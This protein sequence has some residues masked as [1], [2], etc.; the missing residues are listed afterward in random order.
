MA[1]ICWQGCIATHCFIVTTRAATTNVQKLMKY[2]HII[3]WG[4]PLL[5]ASI[6]FLVQISSNFK[7]L[8]YGP[9]GIW[10]F[11]ALDWQ[12]VFLMNI[13]VLVLFLYNVILYAIIL[14][15]CKYSGKSKASKGIDRIIVKTGL[16][17]LTFCF[18]WSGPSA[19][20]LQNLMYPGKP[21]FSLY[22]LH[23]LTVASGGFF[24]ALIYL[25]FLWKDQ[26][27]KFKDISLN[28]IMK[29]KKDVVTESS[30]DSALSSMNV[31]NFSAMQ[32]TPSTGV[33]STFSK[34][35]Y[36]YRP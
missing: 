27:S 8:A 16:Y 32:S 30:C 11:S 36:T 22:F 13:P 24:N 28:K 15:L 26:K 4:F 23:A 18:V 29:K 31:S 6:P 7:V 12:R 35:N 21:M 10:C 20:R 33:E 34:P 25:Y 14:K 9:A 19:N 5:M 2:Y 17:I 3:S 1:A